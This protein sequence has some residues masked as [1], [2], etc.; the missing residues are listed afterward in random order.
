MI[1]IKFLAHHGGHDGHGIGYAILSAETKKYVYGGIDRPFI[2]FKGNITVQQQ[3]KTS[4]VDAVVVGAGFSGLYALHRLRNILGLNAQVYEA[5]GGV[6]GTW[7]WNRYPG[8][9]CDVPSFFYSYS[10][11]E[12]LDQE[13][14]WSEKYA[15]QA[16]IE[17]YLNHVADRFDLRRD[18]RLNTRVISA[19]YNEE[20]CVWV[21]GTD[22]GRHVQAR[23]FISAAGIL[24]VG[25]IPDYNGRDTFKGRTYFTGQWPREGVDFSGQRVGI[26]GTGSTGIQVIPIVAQQAAH[27]TVF[28]RTPNYAIPLRNEPVQVEVEREIKRNYPEIRR[29][30][31]ASPSGLPIDPPSRSALEVSSAERR[32]IYEAGWRAGGFELIAGFKD[33]VTNR[34]ANATISE[35]I[36]EKIRA[37]VHDPELA[38]K[39]VPR[40][41]FGTKRPT[42][43]SG[44]Y[45]ALNRDNVT[46]VDL[47]ATPIE[48]IVPGGI[49]TT[50]AE[51]ELDSIIFATGFDAF[52]G[53]LFRMNIRGRRGIRLEDYWSAGPRTYLGLTSRYFPNMFMITGPQSGVQFNVSRNI[54]HHVEWITDCIEYMY[55]HDY[56]TIEPEE[57]AENRWAEIVNE[58]ANATLIPETDSWWL[59]S[60]I[61]GKPRAILRYIGGAVE[62]QRECAAVAKKNYEGFT[63]VRRRETQRTQK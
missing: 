1:K 61:P 42:M 6:G 13:W 24:S 52:N 5:G 8:A 36:T 39:L 41:P 50:E 47:K 9:R 56:E 4:S 28:Q 44:Y 55:Q 51:Y 58:A 3:V 48:E 62:Y 10:F 26:I 19:T 57:A 59:G 21:I 16:E 32:E 43:E 18:I 38:E 33:L 23:F 20:G 17:K 2:H 25:H 29:K 60:N 14:R 27:L 46:L 7:Y 54:E 37:Q 31:R 30:E 12:E 35:F 34:D 45:E 53:S 22:D 15:S 11:S 49:R 40:H 63:L